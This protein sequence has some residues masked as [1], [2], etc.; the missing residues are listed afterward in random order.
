MD[1]IN[2][3]LSVINVSS[4]IVQPQWGRRFVAMEIATNLGLRRS[5]TSMCNK[6]ETIEYNIPKGFSTLKE[7]V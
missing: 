1:R 4:R 5:T 7:F 3:F 2:Q 6:L